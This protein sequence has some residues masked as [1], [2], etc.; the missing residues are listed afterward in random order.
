MA[1]MSGES[2]GLMNPCSLKP[3]D[4][5]LPAHPY[6]AAAL[7]TESGSAL[8]TAVVV[9]LDFVAEVA[10]LV[11]EGPHLVAEV[12]ALVAA[13]P[14]LAAERPALV[15]EGLDLV[16]AGG[17]SD[18]VKICLGS[19]DFSVIEMTSLTE[20]CTFPMSLD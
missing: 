14:H 5:S 20:S 15:A 7:L 11:A 4:V 2:W 19:S 10:A 9:S 6:L 8:L 17:W 1:S 12:P 13:G 16:S 18:T 3:D